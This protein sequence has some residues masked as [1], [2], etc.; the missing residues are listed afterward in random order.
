MKKEQNLNLNSLFRH[1]RLKKQYTNQLKNEIF[2]LNQI[3]QINY[4][5]LNVILRSRNKFLVSDD[6]RVLYIINIQFS[7]SNTLFHI[8]DFKGNLQFFCSAGSFTYK[9]KQ[10]RNR[11][12]IVKNFLRVLITKFKF[13]KG[14]PIALHLKN[15]NSNRSWLIKQL[16]TKFFIKNVCTLNSYPYNG[17]R[18]SKV[19]RKK[20]KN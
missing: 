4:K 10:K 18:K 8:M 13:L 15:V 19:R 2:S 1:L 12:V 7:K 5:N 6:L 3:K 16:K 9:G 14:K 17:C 20:Y 11:L